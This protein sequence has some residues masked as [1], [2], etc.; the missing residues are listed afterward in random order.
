MIDPAHKQERMAEEKAMYRV[1]SRCLCWCFRAREEMEFE[2]WEERME[3]V[4][5]RRGVR[6]EAI[7]R[8]A[9]HDR[10][11]G[12]RFSYRDMKEICTMDTVKCLN[13]GKRF[14]RSQQHGRG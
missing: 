14:R 12:D 5:A 1:I 4:S 3:A 6:E 7:M 13:L 10:V 9:R 11:L 8:P 2:E